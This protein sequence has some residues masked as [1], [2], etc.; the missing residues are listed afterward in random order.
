MRPELTSVGLLVELANH[1]TTRGASESR[2]VPF[3]TPLYSSYWKGSLRVTLNYG[4]QLSFF[5]IVYPFF[6]HIIF[7]FLFK[8]KIF[9]FSYPFVLL[10][11]P[12][13]FFSFLQ[14]S[15]S[16]FL[17]HPPCCRD[18]EYADYNSCSGSKT[19]PSLV[20]VTKL[21]SFSD[22]TCISGKKKV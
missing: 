21:F 5:L 4:R 8:K 20:H 10:I 16:N 13:F 19:R 22:H 6:Y 12:H 18:L 7:S 11:I 2:V 1:Y 3:P 14:C 17:V 15:L 9:S